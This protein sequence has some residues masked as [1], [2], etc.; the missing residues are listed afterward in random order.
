[1]EDGGDAVRIS[2]LREQAIE[3]I[4]ALAPRT[5]TP[6]AVAKCAT[7]PFT[8]FDC[9]CRSWGTPNSAWRPVGGRWSLAF[10]TG[11]D[12]TIDRDLRRILEQASS[13][14]PGLGAALGSGSGF[15]A[16]EEVYPA[17]GYLER[18]GDL[19]S[20]DG[21]LAGFRVLVDGRRLSDT[22]LECSLRSVTL[23]ARSDVPGSYIRRFP[24]PVPKRPNLEFL[25][26]AGRER[27]SGFTVRYLDDELRI[28]RA[29][30]GAEEGAY[31]VLQRE[32]GDEYGRRRTRA[33]LRAAGGRVTQR[34]YGGWS[35]RGE[36][37]APD[38]FVGGRTF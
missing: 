28:H 38:G 4:E 18:C 13:R 16:F 7:L 8:A 11:P 31:F 14:F 6:R 9:V 3:Y 15:K 10:A 30:D 36:W 29:F 23:L 35:G 26:A 19:D 2:A 34:V 33:E 21:P 1:M 12:A 24:I 37:A 5:P 27:S 22:A 20:F 25:S 17:L 32:V